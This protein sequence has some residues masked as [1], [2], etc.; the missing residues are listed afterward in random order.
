MDSVIAGLAKKNLGLV[1]RAQAFDAGLTRS[2]I[3]YRLKTG[4]LERV[5]RSV[6]RV[7][8]A[9]MSWQQDLLAVQLAL[10]KGALASHRCAA[11]LWTFPGFAPGIKEFS[12]AR[13]RNGN[14]SGLILH[15]PQDLLRIDRGKVGPFLVTDPRRTLLD[16][17]SVVKEDLMED[18]LDDALRR[19]LVSVAS[20]RLRMS[21]MKAKKGLPFLAAALEDRSE[22]LRNESWLEDRFFRSLKSAGLSVPVSQYEIRRKGVLLGRV[23]FAYPDRRVVI[24]CDGYIFH[25][26][27]K[28]WD[29]DAKRA[30]AIMAEGWTIYRFTWTDII[31]NSRPTMAEVAGVLARH[32]PLSRRAE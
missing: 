22:G 32:P 6:Y 30:R 5:R 12:L 4:R 17:A 16:L 25:S 27:R 8:G 21:A 23:D 11:V 13:Q 14:C 3:Y 15:R 7:A 26:G 10:G 28:K 20:M 24:E 2:D 31:E 18:A 19:G 1:T 29:L 9:P